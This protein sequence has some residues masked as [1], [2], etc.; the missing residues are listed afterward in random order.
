[1]YSLIKLTCAAQDSRLLV[2]VMQSLSLFQ[3]MLEISFQDCTVDGPRLIV[4]PRSEVA[5][6]EFRRCT[7]SFCLLTVSKGTICQDPVYIAHLT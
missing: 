3:C 2:C 4:V 1:M 6:I 5:I 7:C